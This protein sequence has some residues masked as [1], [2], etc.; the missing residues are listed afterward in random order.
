MPFIPEDSSGDLNVFG[1]R[2]MIVGVEMPET[3]PWTAENLSLPVRLSIQNAMTLAEPARLPVTLVAVITEPASGRLSSPEEVDRTHAGDLRTAEHVLRNIAG[4]HNSIPVDVTVRTGTAWEELIRSADSRPDHLI[5]CGTRDVQTLGQMLFG[6]TGLKL[7]RLSSGPVWIVKPRIED[8]DSADIVA[9]TDAGPTTQEVL[10]AAVS[11]AKNL[12]ARL[13]VVHCV[14]AASCPTGPATVDDVIQQIKASL[15]E[16]LSATDYR[17][18][19]F[20]VRVIVRHENAAEGI[21]KV[22]SEAGADL[23]V[24]GTS[25]RTSSSEFLP[26]SMIERLLPKLSCSVLAL[27][28]EG[29]RSE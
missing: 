25:S 20:G 18:L 4:T 15:Y 23:L 29:F 10:M 5:V 17:S 13:H 1:I 6:S 28:P 3:Q 7:L 27:K 16:Q 2:R 8:N 24:L 22:V 9:A 14:D 26:G 11:F 21:L 12:N 19:L